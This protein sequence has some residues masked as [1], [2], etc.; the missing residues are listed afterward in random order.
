[1]KKLEVQCAHLFL[2]EIR[3]IYAQVLRHNKKYSQVLLEFQDALKAVSRWDAA[4]KQKLYNKIPFPPYFPYDVDIVYE[5]FLDVVRWVWKEAFLLLEKH[6]TKVEIQKDL[7]RLE[8]ICTECVKDMFRLPYVH[9][10]MKNENENVH[11]SVP[12][13]VVDKNSKEEQE[14][15]D[16]EDDDEEDYEEEDEEDDEEDD[17]IDDEEEEDEDDEE[18]D[19]CN[20]CNDCDDCDDCDDEDEEDDEEYDV[21]DAD[22]DEE[23]ED[24][25][26]EEYHENEKSGE[27]YHD[28]TESESKKGLDDAREAERGLDQ[29]PVEKEHKEEKEEEGDKNKDRQRSTSIEKSEPYESLLYNTDDEESAHEDDLRH[30]SPHQEVVNNFTKHEGTLEPKI[31]Q[32][33]NIK[34][35]T[36]DDNKAKTSSASSSPVSTAHRIDNSNKI[37]D[38]VDKKKQIKQN[39]SIVK[40]SHH[41]KGSFF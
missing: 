27:Y 8:F 24:A 28:K 32:D 38:L 36:V 37:I 35:V 34:I 29:T 30:Q 13:T 12:N 14:S 10:K 9:M 26:E 11:N 40:S 20:D 39:L 15:D 5:C 7:V 41:K 19:D 6:K 33:K 18:D 4:A 16:E 23:S 17:E 21:V 31:E 2:S 25:S 22:E 1:M 3:E